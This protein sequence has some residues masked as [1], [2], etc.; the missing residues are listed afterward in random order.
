[1]GAVTDPRR[2]SVDDLLAEARRR[3]TRAEPEAAW[4]AASAGDAL[5][6]DIRA[7]DE[8]RRD[9][10]V[11]GSLH[12]PRTVLEWRVDESSGWSN[13]HLAGRRR[14]ILLLCAHGCSSSLAAS[15]LVEMGLDAG[16]VRGG[17]E[18]WLAAALPTRRAP[19]RDPDAVPGMAAPD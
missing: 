3:I 11:P 19:E 5:I 6:V 1:M 14:R 2:R 9:G 10:I 8:R 7:D 12:V 17:F 18:A 15:S 13:P 4:A 16:D